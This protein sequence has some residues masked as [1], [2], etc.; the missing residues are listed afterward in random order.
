MHTHSAPNKRLAQ[1]MSEADPHK[2]V[3]DQHSGN[4]W[5]G[6]VTLVPVKSENGFLCY[7]DHSFDAVGTVIKME[8]GL[9]AGMCHGK[10][11]SLR[12]TVRDA[13]LELSNATKH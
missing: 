6:D 3:L 11:M 10:C 7:A 9:W 13:A 8:S 5:T 4:I 12:P 1:E 2:I